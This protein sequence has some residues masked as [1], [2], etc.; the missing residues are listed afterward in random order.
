MKRMG[1]LL[2]MALV[3][4]AAQ[5]QEAEPGATGGHGSIIGALGADGGPQLTQSLPSAQT[6]PDNRKDRETRFYPIT[7]N[8]EPLLHLLE[9]SMPSGS[10]FTISLENDLV[11]VLSDPAGHEVARQFFEHLEAGLAKQRERQEQ[12]RRLLEERMERERIET[13]KQDEMARLQEEALDAPVRLELLVLE[14]IRSDRIVLSDE[15]RMIGLTEE[16]L[17]FLGSRDWRTVG[18]ALIRTQHRR[19]FQTSLVTYGR[20]ED[21]GAFTR[22]MD[23]DLTVDGG[24]VLK[25]GGTL[26]LEVSVSGVLEVIQRG[27]NAEG[28]PVAG[29]D[30]H[31]LSPLQTSADLPVGGTALMGS[32]RI[33]GFGNPIAL[34]VR[35]NWAG[36]EPSAG[37]APTMPT[38]DPATIEVPSPLSHSETMQILARCVISGGITASNQDI[39]DVVTLLN[40]FSRIKF[41]SSPSVQGKVTFSFPHS[42]TI[43]NLLDSVLPN[44]G[45]TYVVAEGGVVHL[46]TA[47][48]KLGLMSGKAAVLPVPGSA[49]ETLK[50]LKET[51]LPKGIAA[52]DGE[53]EDVLTHL[54]Q[55][56]NL[57]FFPSPGVKGKVTFSF[58]TD[59]TVRDV[60]DSIL[61][62]HGWTYVASENGVVHVIQD[63]IR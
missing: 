43:R 49:A 47:D 35:A 46:M 32:T 20:T 31:E 22:T 15:S 17:L 36:G 6:E 48:E 34:V 54:G 59:I 30:D 27:T 23:Y 25:P 38:S 53:I 29:G 56:S 21:E 10:D 62:P 5:A 16:D 57:R 60:L 4:V 37:M 13:A 44:Y 33:R 40:E 41:V 28:Q 2:V 45:W 7:P 11:G 14:G 3:S 24:I 63:E 55:V 12:A 8:L 51:I 19:E 61:P 26:S 39:E 58:Q 1:F 50:I 52:T 18:V 9:N 42:L